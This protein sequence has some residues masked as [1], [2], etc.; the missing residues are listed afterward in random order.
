MIFLL[1]KVIK[2]DLT[3][4]RLC[5]WMNPWMLSMNER[6]TGHRV[7]GAW[8][9]WCWSLIYRIVLLNYLLFSCHFAALRK[10][11]KAPAWTSKHFDSSLATF[12]HMELYLPVWLAWWFWETLRRLEV[13][14]GSL[15]NHFYLMSSFLES[16]IVWA[17]ALF[18]PIGMTFKLSWIRR[19]FQL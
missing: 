11:K 5:R 10:S 18:D 2:K 17:A 12:T 8:K 14:R 4:C 13:L 6:R 16:S 9:C 15:P 3:S 1:K 7:T 19:T